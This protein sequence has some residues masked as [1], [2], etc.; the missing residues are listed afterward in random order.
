M[1]ISDKNR[2]R[3]LIFFIVMGLSILL[4]ILDAIFNFSSGVIEKGAD[5][6]TILS[7]FL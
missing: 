4:L 2:V 6:K 5:S 7:F 1:N 3:L